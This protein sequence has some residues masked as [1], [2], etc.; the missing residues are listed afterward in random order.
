M[1]VVVLAILLDRG[2]IT[3]NMFSAL[4]MMALV[5]TLL[6]TP[7]TRWVLSGEHPSA[8]EKR[9]GVHAAAGPE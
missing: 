1:E 5:S 7:L 6:A 3:T 4:M 8:S 2:V 9:D